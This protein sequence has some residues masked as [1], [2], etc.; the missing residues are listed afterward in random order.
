MAQGPQETQIGGTAKGF[1]STCWTLVLR[2]KEADLGA[3]QAA[4]EQ[5]ALAY[6]KPLYFFVRRRGN[7]VETSKDLIQGYFASLLERDTFQYLDRTRGK[8]R[9][10]LLTTL[11]HY[12]ADEHDRA[13]AMKRGGGRPELSLDVAAAEGQG[14]HPGAPGESPD[15]AFNR[16][17]AIGVLTQALE[18]LRAAYEAFGGGQEFDALRP[19]LSAMRPENAS[20]EEL[21]RRLGTT[22]QD[23]RSRVRTAR[24]RYRDSILE[25]IRSYAETPEEAQEELR[26]LFSAFS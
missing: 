19:H 20:Y 26:E 9:T 24:T 5:L 2:A 10:F 21:A 23:I 7:S 4:L 14:L 25:V 11:E 16:E 8:F 6:W 13:T 15:Q 22:V 17:W 1:T 12:L 3:R 18:K